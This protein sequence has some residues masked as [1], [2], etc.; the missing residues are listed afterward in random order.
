MK[1]WAELLR[2]S[3]PVAISFGLLFFGKWMIENPSK[4]PVDLQDWFNYVGPIFMIIG[5]IGLVVILPHMV[6]QSYKSKAT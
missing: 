1:V 3:P 2:S 4:I 5:G 6:I